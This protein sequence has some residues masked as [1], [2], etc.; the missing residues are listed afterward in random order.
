[1]T[2]QAF[3]DHLEI[4]AE[5]AQ[6]FERLVQGDPD[7]ADLGA[8]LE[9]PVDLALLGRGRNPRM[10][11]LVLSGNHAGDELGIHPIG[12]A[13]QSHTLGIVTNVLGIEH[14]DHQTE[15]VAR[16]GEQLMVA[17]RRF[18]ADAAACRQALEQRAQLGAAVAHLAPRECAFGTCDDDF[19]LAHVGADIHCYGWG[20]HDVPPVA[21][22]ETAGVNAHRRE[23]ADKSAVA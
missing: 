18:H 22:L 15:L 2:V 14:E 16:L 1:M 12:F 3:I 10:Q 23:L 5:S 13:A 20:L 4:G 17:T 11:L 7:A 9:Q 21:T 8:A 6:A 19:V